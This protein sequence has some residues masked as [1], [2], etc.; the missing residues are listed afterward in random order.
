MASSG[1]A[2]SGQ[3]SAAQGPPDRAG[4]SG[5]GEAPPQSELDGNPPDD[6][7]PAGSGSEPSE[8]GQGE[9][10]G[11]GEMRAEP[12]G[13]A[14]SQ[15]PPAEPAPEEP[16]DLPPVPGDFAPPEG[17]S[18]GASAAFVCAGLDASGDPLA[19]VSA[20]DVQSF[21]APPG[22][23]FAFLEGPIWVAGEGTVYFSDNARDPERI[24]AL[25]PPSTQTFLFKADAGS[26][27]LALDSTDRLLLADERE[28]RITRVD[29][30]T[31]ELIETVLPSGDVT[32]NDLILRSDG[33]LYFTD[34]SRGLFRRAPD[35][36]VQGALNQSNTGA[37]L[38]NANGVVL[39]TDE[40]LLYVG[41]VFNRSVSTFNLL[42]DGSIDAASGELFVT[43][44]AGT[45][46]G[47]AVDCAGNL[48]VGTDGGVEVYSPTGESLGVVPTGYSSNC[49]FGGAD[50]RTL[51]VTSQGQLKA[52]RLG[53]PG[54]PN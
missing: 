14:E 36:A 15:P 26:N 52:V 25:T 11:G 23:F 40:T 9:G 47:M 10:E 32:P 53:V 21:G 29:P 37:P 22:D 12:E 48:Y 50:R 38:A 34:P 16:Q 42:A 7:R 44:S 18:G 27:G 35:G 39:S 13:D 24:Y 28:N 19:G 4:A 20:A 45:V 17:L 46:D 8:S 49:T 31:A 43:T 6:A 2:S 3:G 54:L 51:F 33:N 30:S 5:G 1:Q 41:S